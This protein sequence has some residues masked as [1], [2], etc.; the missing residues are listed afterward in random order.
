MRTIQYI[1]CLVFDDPI[2]TPDLIQLRG[3]SILLIPG[4]VQ[5]MGESI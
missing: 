1:Y 2:L 4:F 5:L 3:T